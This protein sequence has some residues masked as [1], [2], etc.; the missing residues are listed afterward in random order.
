MEVNKHG[1]FGH[2]APHYASLNV[3][4]G[5]YV[6]SGCPLHPP[7]NKLG[8][9]DTVPLIMPPFKHEVG[10]LCSQLVPVA[11]ATAAALA[12]QIGEWIV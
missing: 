9:L 5:Y 8:A 10:A 2:C 6:L 3:S 7:V 1:S 11:S 12:F 4:W